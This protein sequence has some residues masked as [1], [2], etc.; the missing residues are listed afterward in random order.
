MFAPTPF[1]GR[2]V[3]EGPYGV[4]K[5]HG[6]GRNGQGIHI[7]FD[8]TNVQNLPAKAGMIPVCN[9]DRGRLDDS[10]TEYKTD[11]L[12]RQ[13][14]PKET[15]VAFTNARAHKIAVVIK[16]GDATVALSAVVGT[17]RWG[18]LTGFTKR[19]SGT[20]ISRQYYRRWC[21]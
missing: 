17:D 5:Q 11:R 14:P 20:A 6:R 19:A 3:T 8:E 16:R 7:Y 2:R 15:P 10:H 13:E 9:V 21:S 4:N 18:N 12:G 1:K